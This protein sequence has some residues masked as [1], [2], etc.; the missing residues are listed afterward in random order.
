MLPSCLPSLPQHQA[1]LEENKIN[2]DTRDLASHS[3]VGRGR[4]SAPVQDYGDAFF[5][6]LR[7]E[8]HGM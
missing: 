4:D 8:S 7:W 3:F 1:P 6:G 2:P 5:S